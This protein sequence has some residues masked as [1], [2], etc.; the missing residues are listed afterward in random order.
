MSPQ[1]SAPSSRIRRLIM[2]RSIRSLAS[3]C[4]FATFT[5]A[6]SPGT[7]SPEANAQA[8]YEVTPTIAIPKNHSTWSLFLVCNPAWI[9]QNGDQ[10]IAELFKQ[11]K[12]FG[13][14][15]GPNN[16]AIW[17]WKKP[18]TPT[19][20]NTDV[21]R[22][23]TYCERY[24]LLPSESPHVLVTTSYPDDAHRSAARD[25]PQSVRNRCRRQMAA[26]ACRRWLRDQQDRMLLQQGIVLDQDRRAQRRDCAL[27]GKRWTWERLLTGSQSFSRRRAA[28]LSAAR[29]RQ[30]SPST[31]GIETILWL[32]GLDDAVLLRPL[33]PFEKLVVD[34]FELL[35]Q[36]VIIGEYH[37]ILA[38]PAGRRSD[39]TVE[40]EPG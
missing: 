12:A 2:A 34:Y 5:L 16:L 30:G 28:A 19:A 40:A 1:S 32:G 39:K 31:R 9:L 27:G 37:Q 14:A 36:G 25:R 15:I 38:G 3:A 20:D 35:A 8:S 23:S 22:S 21:S 10:G 17:F 4:V 7:I 33:P 11:Y 29:L 24:K 18:G 6:I 26:N 13:D